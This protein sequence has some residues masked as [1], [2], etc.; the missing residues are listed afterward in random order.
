MYNSVIVVIV[1]GFEVFYLSHFNQFVFVCIVTMYDVDVVEDVFIV[2]VSI[3]YDKLVDGN[4][5]KEQM[6]Q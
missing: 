2:P 5:N 4:F 6:V 1:I 3:S